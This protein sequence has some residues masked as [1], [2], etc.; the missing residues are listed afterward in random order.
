MI[1]QGGKA[2]GRYP[3]W[4][5]VPFD[6]NI[7]SPRTRP[8]CQSAS[9]KSNCG[10]T[11]HCWIPSGSS[12][13]QAGQRIPY[14]DSTHESLKWFVVNHDI[15]VT[16]R[17]QKEA[18]ATFDDLFGIGC[19]PRNGFHQQSLSPSQ[20]MESIVWQTQAMFDAYCGKQPYLLLYH[21]SLLECAN[22][23]LL[24]FAFQSCL[25]VSRDIF[26]GHEPPPCKP[27]ANYYSGKKET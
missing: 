8:S 2:Q 25:M 13:Q 24:S 14:N 12:L 10:R 22:Q 15:Y 23:V 9:Q 3:R 20:E 18:P 7:F 16:S 4:V 26:F 5:V 17:I 6:H 27:S 21:N 19:V 1:V 11:W